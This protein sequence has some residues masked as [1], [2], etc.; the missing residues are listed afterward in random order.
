MPCRFWLFSPSSLIIGCILIGLTCALFC[1]L[2]LGHSRIPLSSL[3]GG[4]ARQELTIQGL[5]PSF[6][7]FHSST[8][9]WIRPEDGD[10]RSIY[11]ISAPSIYAQEVAALLWDQHTHQHIL[12]Q[13]SLDFSLAALHSVC[14]TRMVAPRQGLCVHFS[15]LTVLFCCCLGY[16][17]TSVWRPRANE[18]IMRTSPGEAEGNQKS[19]S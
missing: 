17:P 14:E 19:L 7:S 11:I 5:S 3:M 6:L 18:V 12:G 10:S 8:T 2:R 4:G 15:V 13:G 16:W 9:G 1:T